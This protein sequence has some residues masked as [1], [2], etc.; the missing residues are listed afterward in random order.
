MAQARHAP[1]EDAKAITTPAAVLQST[2]PV[3]VV[4][5]VGPGGFDWADAG[6]GAGAAGGA[7]TLAGALAM[8][9]TRRSRA[10]ALPEQRELAGA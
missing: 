7:L 1:G 10:S 3:S 5:A 6:I 2:V 9:A 4:K 8:L